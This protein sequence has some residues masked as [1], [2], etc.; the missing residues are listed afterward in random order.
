MISDSVAMPGRRWLQ[1]VLVLAALRKM[2]HLVR[3]E[4]WGVT[5]LDLLKGHVFVRQDW[6]YRWIDDPSLPAWTH[7]ERFDFH[8]RLDRLIWTHWSMRARLTVRPAHAAAP[9]QQQPHPND[10]STRFAENGLTLSFDV[11]S[12]VGPAHWQANVVKVDSQKRPL[13]RDEYE[14]GNRF[15]GDCNSIMNIGRHIRAR[16]LFLVAETVEK[17]A[18]GCKFQPVVE[19]R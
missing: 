15:F 10:L 16:H 4:P 5:D 12:V 3:S 2:A 18:P 8:H 7:Q 17:M 1:C 9:P 14:R 6:R 13:P 11:R 19:T